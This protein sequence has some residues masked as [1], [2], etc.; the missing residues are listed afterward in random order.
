MVADQQ[1]L[2][3]VAANLRAVLADSDGDPAAGLTVTVGVTKADG[4]EVVAAGTS[5]PEDPDAAGTYT[6]AV[7]AAQVATLEWLAAT[8]KV[9]GVTRA[10]TVH[11]VVGGYYCSVA[12]AHT[13]EQFGTV[14]A[15][16]LRRVRGEVEAEFEQIT[17]VAF[18]PRYARVRVDGTGRTTLAVPFSQV[19]SVR[20][21]RVYSDGVTYTTFTAGE[22]AAVP[23]S[24]TG[25]LVRTDGAVWPTGRQNIIIEIE[26]GYSSVPADVKRA[27][28]ARLR[29][30][31]NQAAS[32]IPSNAL[33]FA[34]ENGQTFRLSVPA[35]DRTGDVDVD[36]VLARHSMRVGIA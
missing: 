33:S 15:A 12:D 1:L 21:V 4:T 25:L 3:G 34:T 17:G 26:H 11:E 2:R 14:P 36:A 24:R 29:S 7:S 32:G 23:A 8:W 6:V 22:L 35:V 20:S 10:V 19:T 27:A 18:V 28:I 31:V 30:R 16:T 9:A 13:V 5:A